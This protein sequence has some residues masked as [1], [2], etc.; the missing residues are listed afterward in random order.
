[1]R[2]LEFCAKFLEST[3]RPILYKENGMGKATRVLIGKLGLDGHESGARIIARALRDAGMEVIYAGLR[4]TPEMIVQAAIQE[5]VDIIGLSFLSGAHNELSSRVLQLLKQK[6]L[7]EIPVLV[8]GIIPAEDIPGMKAMGVRE[9]FGPGT[10]TRHVAKY[11]QNL[12]RTKST[13]ST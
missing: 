1:M 13:A 12:S 6:G 11:V 8:G 7:E 9:V 3:N 5:D 10:D 2:S 4:Q